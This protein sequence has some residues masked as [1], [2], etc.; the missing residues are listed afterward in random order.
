MYDILLFWIQ[1]AGKGTQAKLLIDAMPWHF[2]Y[3]SSWDIFRALCSAPNAIWD[4]LKARMEAGELIND[5]VTNSLFATYFHTVLDEKKFMLLDGFPR[6]VAQMEVM[7][8]LTNTHERKLLGIEFTLPEDV[9]I[10]RLM[11]RWRSDDNEEAIKNRINQFHKK[12]QPV[13]DWFGER[14]PL[15]RIDANRS[16]EEIHA[17][18]L[19]QIRSFDS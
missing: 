11:G 16:V 18:T 2:S 6:S 1:W 7:M 13:L 12:T 19:Q 15:L 14:A 3:F 17:D 5:K 8:K 4:Y 10:E 9:A